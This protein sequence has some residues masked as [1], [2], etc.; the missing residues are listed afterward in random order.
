MSEDDETQKR[1][2][3]CVYWPQETD[4]TKD[5]NSPLRKVLLFCPFRL[6]A[7]HFCFSEEQRLSAVCVRTV[8]LAIPH[9][10]ARSR[11][12]IGKFDGEDW[13]SHAPYHSHL[14]SMH[15]SPSV[16]VRIVKGSITECQY[17][18]MSYSIPSEFLPITNTGN[19][20]IQNHNKWITYLE[21]KEAA[22]REDIVFYGIDCPSVKDILAGK[23]PH[24][25]NHPGNIE[26]R[27]IMESRFEEH[28]DAT[29]IDRKTAITWE[30]VLECQRRGA[31]FLIKDK[32]W[33]VV[34]DQD[35]AREKVSVAFRDMRKSYAT[36]DQFKSKK[37]SELESVFQT[38]AKKR[39]G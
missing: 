16:F 22:M 4:I 38:D 31:R 12:H 15:S 30:V 19:I 7:F 9:L 28:R 25:S 10:K 21:S 6:S 1:G 27:K 17:Q 37:R 5:S 36:K 3:V 34:A 24:V 23:G 11:I 26:F 2:A 13:Q 8:L 29:V 20:K 39:K 14:E 33:W 35:T 32:N 18:L